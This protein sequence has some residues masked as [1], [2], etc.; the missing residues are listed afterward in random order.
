MHLSHLDMWYVV[1]VDMHVDM[2]YDMSILPHLV[3]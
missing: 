3:V 2:R 1:H